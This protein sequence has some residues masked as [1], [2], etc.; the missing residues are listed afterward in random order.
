MLSDGTEIEEDST[1]SDNEVD[2]SG[3][4]RYSFKGKKTARYIN[5]SLNTPTL[6]A[7]RRQINELFGE[8]DSG[9]ANGVAVEFGDSVYIVDAGVEDGRVDYGVR[10]KETISDNDLRK[11]YIRRKNGK[12]IREG[13]ISDGLSSKFG[14]EYVDDW[15]NYFGRKLGDELSDN[16]RKSENNESRISEKDATDGRRRL[17]FSLK[18]GNEDVSGTVEETN[19]LVALHNLSEQNLLKVIDLGGFPMPSIAVTTTAPVPTTAYAFVSEKKSQFIT[20]LSKFLDKIK[21]KKGKM[22]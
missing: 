18:I 2:N 4:I 7:I 8:V 16:T 21:N 3:E 20:I 13:Y 15:N 6:S 11:E 14:D 1:E 22:I 17:K 9:I 12:S 10:S 5:N 19:N